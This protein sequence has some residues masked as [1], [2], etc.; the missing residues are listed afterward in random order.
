[1]RVLKTTSRLRPMNLFGIELAPTKPYSFQQVKRLVAF[2]TTDRQVFL[3]RSMLL[4]LVLIG[5]S[6][7]QSS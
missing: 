1:M 2:T 6:M 3:D 4:R 7:I 5:C